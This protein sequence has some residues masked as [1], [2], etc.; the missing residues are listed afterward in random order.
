MPAPSPSAPPHLPVARQ[1]IWTTSGRLH[2]HEYLYR[3][4]AGLPVGV[5]R[6]SAHLQDGATTAVLTALF[7]DGPPPGDALAFVN[8]TRSFLV[9]DLPLPPSAGR[10]VIEV[11]ESVEAGPDVLDGLLRLRAAG[12]RI[13]LDDFV[14]SRDQLAMLRYADYVKIDCRDLE[15][16]GDE[17]VRVARAFGARLVAERVS[18]S[19]RRA[20]C[21]ELGFGLLQGDALG[22]A[23][24]LTL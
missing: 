7:H 12:Y 19:A 6:W 20:R 16:G 10:L 8:V 21:V 5:D 22:R 17:L 1:P 13:A 14:A 9:R 23:V 4:S 2:G 3:S 15:T 24:T 11:V 18:S